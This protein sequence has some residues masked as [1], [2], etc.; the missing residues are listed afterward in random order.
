MSKKLL[1]SILFLSLLFVGCDQNK[2]NNEGMDDG[3]LEQTDSSQIEKDKEFEN[4]DTKPVVDGYLEGGDLEFAD[5]FEEFV[6]GKIDI[7]RTYIPEEI[8]KNALI[9]TWEVYKDTDE[10]KNLQKELKESKSLYHDDINNSKGILFA[11]DNKGSFH[12]DLIDKK[13]HLKDLFAQ[14]IYFEAHK[15]LDFT[16]NG[17]DVNDYTFEYDDEYNL[18][19]FKNFPRYIDIKIEQE[20]LKPIEFRKNILDS[21]SNFSLE[22]SYDIDLSDIDQEKV[23][24]FVVDEVNKILPLIEKKSDVSE[25]KKYFKDGIDEA[26]FEEIYTND[27]DVE[28]KNGYKFK[29]ESIMDFSYAFNDT[30]KIKI[31]GPLYYNITGFNIEDS[32]M[33]AINAYVYFDKDGNMKLSNYQEILPFLTTQY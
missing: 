25:I 28:D 26:L 32:F 27:F 31:K 18:F 29:K 10:F 16:I 7:N 20:Y 19:I 4:K 12:F 8:T 22:Q 13:V 14:T 23:S 30:I 1:I 21:E 6:E 33:H 9:N 2:E 24:N 3:V 5:Y 17:V 15:N 11:P